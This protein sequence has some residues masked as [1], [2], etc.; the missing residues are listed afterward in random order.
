MSDSEYNSADELESS[1]YGTYDDTMGR[2]RSIVPGSPEWRRMR[3]RKSRHDAYLKGSRE[4]KAKKAD[5]R[6]R[7]KERQ[8]SA[9]SYQGSEEPYQGSKNWAKYSSKEIDV[10]V[11]PERQRIGAKSKAPSSSGKKKRQPGEVLGILI[12]VKDDRRDGKI[13]KTTNYKKVEPKHGVNGGI[14][15]GANIIKNSTAS[16]DTPDTTWRNERETKAAESNGASD[17]ANRKQQKAADELLDTS[18]GSE[19]DMDTQIEEMNSR[20]QDM[21]AWGQ[22][23]G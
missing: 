9:E 13:S 14:I 15:Q 11:T 22:S 20:I 7:K 17:N 4:K 23:L 18:T 1:G 12:D 21:E 16:E 8:R 2:S 5:R 3:E 19:M 10:A 6:K